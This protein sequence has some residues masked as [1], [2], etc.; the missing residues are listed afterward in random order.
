[1]NTNEIVLS[2]YGR[3]VAMAAPVLAFGRQEGGEVETACYELVRLRFGDDV[4]ASAH[5][6]S[7]RVGFADMTRERLFTAVE[8]WGTP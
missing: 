4:Q 2:T 5:L 8:H 1:M 3:R 6:A 7:Y